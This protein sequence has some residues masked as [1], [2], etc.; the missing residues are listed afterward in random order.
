MVGSFSLFEQLFETLI[1]K[2]WNRLFLCTIL[3]THTIQA[4]SLNN[5]KKK[6]EPLKELI[7]G[8][9]FTKNFSVSIGDA[10]GNLFTRKCIVFKS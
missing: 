8:W 2:M 5:N 4:F 1:I 3:I 7:T 9:E 6:W 10:S